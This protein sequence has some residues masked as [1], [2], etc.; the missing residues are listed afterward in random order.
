MEKKG[1]GEDE[2]RVK[3]N[4]KGSLEYYGGKGFEKDSMIF[5]LV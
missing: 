3:K 4:G 2:G 1:R 5:S